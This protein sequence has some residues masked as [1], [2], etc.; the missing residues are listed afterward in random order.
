MNYTFK[1]VGWRVQKCFSRSGG[2]PRAF[3]VKEAKVLMQSYG[4]K[5]RKASSR[6]KTRKEHEL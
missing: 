1:E 6:E 2:K 3:S 4:G 5:Y